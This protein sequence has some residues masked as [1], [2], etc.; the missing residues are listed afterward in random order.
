ML[1]SLVSRVKATRRLTHSQFAIILTVSGN[2]ITRFQM[3][4]DSFNVSN[5][6]RM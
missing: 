2:L 5:A 6:V 3:L 4:E 1:G